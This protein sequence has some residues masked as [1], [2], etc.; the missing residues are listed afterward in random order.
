MGYEGA[1]GNELYFTKSGTVYVERENRLWR[2]PLPDGAE[3][4]VAG[5]VAGRNFETAASGVYFIEESPSG[6]ALRLLRYGTQSAET[7]TVLGGTDYFGITISPDEHV[8]LYS[9][10]E[11]THSEL[12]LV[13]GFGHSR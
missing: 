6:A 10:R 7:I 9:R 8:A 12:M 3:E 11:V 4:Q 2:M 5:P 1:G 13:E